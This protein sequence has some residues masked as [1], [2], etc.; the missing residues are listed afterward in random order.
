MHELIVLFYNF[1]IWCRNE[2]WK[3]RTNE[4]TAEGKNAF[5]QQVSSHSSF[6]RLFGYYSLGPKLSACFSSVLLLFKLYTH[7]YSHMYPYIKSAHNSMRFAC[8][9]FIH[10]QDQKNPIHNVATENQKKSS[11]NNN[12][13][14]KKHIKVINC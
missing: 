7:I 14:N 9:A 6:V 4:R 11:N 12:H 2:L 8:K 10:K 5:S 3:Y 1:K 13:N